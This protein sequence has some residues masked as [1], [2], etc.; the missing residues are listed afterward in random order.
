MGAIECH[1][2]LKVSRKNIMNLIKTKSEGADP[3]PRALIKGISEKENHEDALRPAV[4]EKSKVFKHRIAFCGLFLITLLMYLRPQ[5]VLP[6]YFGSFP[7][8]KVVAVATLL[9]YVVSKISAGQSMVIW[10]L[11]LT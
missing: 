4:K 5:E 7:Q 8:T 3:M 1:L 2:R 6:K 11:E 10:S 9:I